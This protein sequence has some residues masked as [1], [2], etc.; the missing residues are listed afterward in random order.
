[1][2]SLLTPKREC[3][4]CTM[5]NG[6]CHG[7][8]IVMTTSQSLEVFVRC[9]PMIEGGN[10]R[11]QAAKFYGCLPRLLERAGAKMSDVVIERVFFRDIAG[12]FAEFQSIRQ[13][14][15][16]QAGVT[17]EQL[18]VASYIHQPPCLAGQAYEMQI[19]AIVPHG[20]GQVKVESFAELEPRVTKKVIQIGDHRHLYIMNINGSEPDGT[21]PTD[22]RRQSDNMFAKS[23]PMLA[24]HGIGFR[25]VLRTWC[26][27][28]EIDRDYDEFNRSRNAF[29]AEHDVRRLP[30][31]TGIR[32]AL[33]PPQALCSF[34]LYALLD[35]D[36]VEVEVMHTPTLNEA[37]E[38]GSAFSRGMKVV[39]PEKTVLFI[40]GTASVDERGETVHLNDVRRQVER[41]LLNV[42]E[43]L[44]P[45]GAK[46]SDVAQII[47]Y[48]KRS[49]YLPTFMDVWRDWGLTGLPNSFVEAGV[50]RPNLLCELEA[51]V[52]LPT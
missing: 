23:V 25:D 38:Y 2:T 52:I 35:L 5:G 18:P 46:F 14:A 50:C 27:L 45:H 47:T 39:L 24:E 21:I 36:G 22:F 33:Y 41:M 3:Q 37:D 51:I 1:M 17:G 10:S 20:S 32:A 26:Y 34:D 43:L 28:D 4:C 11:E 12:D 16:A 31:S 13:E 42:R 49:S 44:R 8:V 9:G 30:A 7:E 40:S 6:V 19:Q 48:L 29:F 15:Y